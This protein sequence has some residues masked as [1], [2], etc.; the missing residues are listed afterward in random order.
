M[1]PRLADVVEAMASHRPYRAALGID[2]AL[3]EI[4]IGLTGSD[5][6]I[7]DAGAVVLAKRARTHR[8]VMNCLVFMSSA[9]LL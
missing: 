2:A 5:A 4:V 1:V 8:A 9:P 7:A 3:G 6:A